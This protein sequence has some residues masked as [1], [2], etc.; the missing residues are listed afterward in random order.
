[1]SRD[2]LRGAF[3]QHNSNL[4]IFVGDSFLWTLQERNLENKILAVLVST[5]KVTEIVVPSGDE[6]IVPSTENWVTRLELEVCFTHV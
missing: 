4:K 2:S 6:G 3:R 1:M 5:D